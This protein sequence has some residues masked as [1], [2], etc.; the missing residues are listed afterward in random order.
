MRLASNKRFD[1]GLRDVPLKRDPLALRENLV[2]VSTSAATATN[3]FNLSDKS[4][5][6]DPSTRLALLAGSG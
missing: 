3:T 4:L 5:R 6:V 2:P 1:Q